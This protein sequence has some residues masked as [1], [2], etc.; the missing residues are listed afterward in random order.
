MVARMAQSNIERQNDL[1]NKLTDLLLA[2]IEGGLTHDRAIAAA[3]GA[4]AVVV[5]ALPD[6]TR[7]EACE[8]LDGMLLDHANRYAERLRSGEYDEQGARSTGN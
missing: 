5:G 7:A 3:H 2:A 6:A 8:L 4:L 1:R